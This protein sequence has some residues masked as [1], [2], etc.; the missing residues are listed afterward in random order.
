MKKKLLTGGTVKATITNIHS[1]FW[2]SLW[3]DPVLDPDGKPSLFLTQQLSGYVN[4]DP[5]KKQQRALP[6]SV[7]NQLLQNEITLY[8]A[9][10]E[11]LAY[12]VFF[13]VMR[14]C[15]YLKVTGTCIIKR[16]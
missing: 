6:V 14:S 11:S 9:A 3:A 12:W 16:K 5:L 2:M 10:I 1:C 8:N 13:F 7:F 4:A 15:E